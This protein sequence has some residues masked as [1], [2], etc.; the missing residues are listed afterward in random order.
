MTHYDEFGLT[1]AALPEEIQRAHRNLARLLH[2]DPIQD[3]E[4]RRL[5]ENQLKRLNHV[6]S[7]LIDPVRRRSYDLQLSNNSRS[8][9]GMEFALVPPYRYPPPPPPPQVALWRRVR[10]HVPVV[11]GLS[12]LAGFQAAVT[13]GTPER[14]VFVDRLPPAPLLGAAIPLPSGPG[15]DGPLP[16]TNTR[17]LRSMLNQALHERDMA[18]AKLQVRPAPAAL[19]A[20]AAN[21]QVQAAPGAAAAAAAAAEPPR[22]NNAVGAAMPPPLADPGRKM[23]QGNLA[24]TWIYSALGARLSPDD[25]YPAEYIELVLGER[26]DLVSGRYR[27]RYKVADR[28]LSP[29]VEF[30]FH[31][32]SAGD[33]R[34]GWRGNGG[35]KG[36]IHL[37]LLSDNALSLNWFTS[38]LGQHPMLGSGT[39]VLVRRRQD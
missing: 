24:G 28:A 36:E 31:G 13:Y 2:P 35:A 9:A 33:R 30:F 32:S 12:L 22:G 16:A 10:W 38:Q 23:A 26:D 18:L 20:E 27:A 19:L 8:G 17:D 7:V 6:Y 39:A 4:L 21:P 5:A 25:Q 29:E 37:K 11:A 14:V 1:P 15:E 3:E 34:Y